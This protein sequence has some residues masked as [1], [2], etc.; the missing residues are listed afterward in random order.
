MKREGFTLVE[1]LAMLVVLGILMAVAIPNI[2]GI[3]R[4]NKLNVIK[5]DA[6]KMVD[7]AKIKM[8][9][10][11]EDKL[12][13][14]GQC[15]VFSLNYLNDSEDINTGPNGGEYLKFESFVVVKKV[16]VPGSPK[17]SK[18]EYY[19][20]LVENIKGGGFGINL[21]N[22]SLLSDENTEHI[23]AVKNVSASEELQ[24]IQE[25]DLEKLSTR[26][27]S[28]PCSCSKIVVYQP[29]VILK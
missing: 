11:K 18:Y 5:S 21:A 26:L 13:E 2:T 9:S 10:L 14:N 29:G 22:I 17:T 20:R 16:Q 12:P 19:V 7:T 15:V 24:G 1:L 4:N 3:L 8:S 28:D 23:T 6:I 27:R 25:E